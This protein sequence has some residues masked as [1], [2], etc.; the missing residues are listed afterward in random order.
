MTLG[1]SV[2]LPLAFDDFAAA[3]LHRDALHTGAAHEL[4]RKWPSRPAI[5]GSLSSIFQPLPGIFCSFNVGP[6]KSSK[7]Q[8]PLIVP[9]TVPS[10]LPLSFLWMVGRSW[11]TMRLLQHWGTAVLCVDW[12]A[13]VPGRRGMRL[14]EGDVFCGGAIYV[15]DHVVREGGRE[16]ERSALYGRTTDGRSR[17][18][19]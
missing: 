4:S 15:Q 1:L 6:V 2:A 9:V 13:P 3:A 12:K 14:D 19:T 5:I 11:V 7:P 8:E 10:V 17:Q 16:D 18:V